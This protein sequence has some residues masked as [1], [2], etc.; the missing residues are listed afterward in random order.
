MLWR[1]YIHRHYSFIRLA[2]CILVIHINISIQHWVHTP[3]KCVTCMHRVAPKEVVTL[4][5]EIWHDKNDDILHVSFIKKFPCS[6]NPQKTGHWAS[7][8][9][10]HLGFHFPIHNAEAG[11][12]WF[13]HKVTP[14]LEEAAG[15]PYFPQSPNSLHGDQCGLWPCLTAQEGSRK[16]ER[17]CQPGS[18]WGTGAQSGD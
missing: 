9:G 10:I 7:W 8:Q 16:G 11:V 6:P 18:R 15:F 12:S 4:A 17:E 2:S 1:T 5:S 14:E 3:R 13:I